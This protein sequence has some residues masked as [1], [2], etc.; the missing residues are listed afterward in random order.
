MGWRRNVG[1]LQP[2]AALSFG[3]G[4]RRFAAAGVALDRDAVVAEAGLAWQATSGLSVGVSYAGEVGSRARD[5][6]LKGDLT[7]RF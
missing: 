4:G 3:A 1:D 2:A 7:W 5:H 6:A